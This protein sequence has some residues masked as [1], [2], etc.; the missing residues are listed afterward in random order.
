MAT[1]YLDLC[2][3][4]LIRLREDTIST[5]G[6]SALSELDDP[7][8]TMV[9]Q[10]VNDAK[11]KVESAHNWNALRNEWSVDTVAGTPSY[12]L[13]GAGEYVIIEQVMDANGYTLRE[14]PINQIRKLA[15]GENNTPKY[16][17]VD[18]VDE[19]GDV[20]LRLGPTPKDA[21]TFTVYGFSGTA[22]LDVDT[23]KLVIP[24]KPVVYFALAL[25]ARERGEVGGQTSTDLFGAATSYVNEAIAL[26][27]QNNSLDDIW[28]TV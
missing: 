3:E 10:F 6:A 1:T 14:G 11:R 19:D 24:A 27:A 22:D 21:D 12:S 13:T 8:A 25:A 18:G 5:V 9:K 20:K 17:S 16:W 26:D 7:V 2:N 28:Y 4:V 23:D 15:V